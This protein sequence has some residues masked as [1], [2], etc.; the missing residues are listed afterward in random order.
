MLRMTIFWIFRMTIYGPSFHFLLV[1]DRGFGTAE[2]GTLKYGDQLSC[3]AF[4]WG[5][6]DHH[7]MHGMKRSR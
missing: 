7:L 1:K 6:R 5:V 4:M 3:L 2:H